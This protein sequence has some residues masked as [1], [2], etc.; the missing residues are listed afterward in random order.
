MPEVVVVG[1][2]Q[3]ITVRTTSPTATSDV[4]SL[5]VGESDRKFKVAFKTENLK[6][7]GG[8]YAVSLTEKAAL[9]RGEDVT[10]A[11]AAEIGSRFEK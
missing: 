5:D 6:L 8:D 2:G 11:I 1:D 4:F 10:Y 7:I 3:Q 9:F